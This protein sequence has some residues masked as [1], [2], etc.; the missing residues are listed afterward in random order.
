MEVPPRPGAAGRASA[1]EE[2]EGDADKVIEV[3]ATEV[4]AVTVASYGGIP[5]RSPDNPLPDVPDA[6]LIEEGL[7]GPLPMI[8]ADGREPWKVYGR[9]TPL[10]DDRPQIAI[11]V[12]GLGLSAAATEAA[13]RLLPAGV[14]LAF[15]P[16]GKGLDDWVPLA[17]RYGHEF[18]IYVPTEPKEFPVV[19]PG[20]YALET[21]L[22]AA[23][24]LRR[25]EF[26][27]SRVSGYVGVVT[28]TGSF[29]TSE[30]EYVQPILD[31]IKSRGLMIVD[32][33]GGTGQ[34]LPEI[35][36]RI[37]LPRVINDLVLDVEPSKV[38]I[39][40]QLARLEEISREKAVAVAIA[41]PYP[42]TIERI[43]AWAASLEQKNLTLVPVSSLA[44]RQFIQ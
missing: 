3:P 19:D 38:S 9:P 34:V 14:T 27:L 41:E 29:F 18:L 6:G 37:E 8:G 36:T 11:I 39:D 23:E 10:A 28:G 26:V 17:R 5:E 4:P 42:A 40:R 16:Y 1:P 35:A 12:S 30:E 13:I 31:A 43:V 20:P 33:G 22:D 15:D 21:V 2:G 32:G 25:L 44:D 24:N 7:H